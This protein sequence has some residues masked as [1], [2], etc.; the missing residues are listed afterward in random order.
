MRA[1]LTGGFIALLACLTPGV[2]A[3]DA[4]WRAPAANAANAPT[5]DS[6]VPQVTLGA[7]VPLTNDLP[8]QKEQPVADAG[9][10]QAAYQPPLPASPI[11]QAQATGL[12][13]PTLSPL[14]PPP[15]GAEPYNCGVANQ[16][17]DMNPG[18]WA[19]CKEFCG[20]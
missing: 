14:P 3:G 13:T 18:F 2:Q 4:W 8:V 11:I 17:P 5:A 10:M 19:K 7:P 16:G 20:E 12:P 6:Q 15:G 1:V 9:I